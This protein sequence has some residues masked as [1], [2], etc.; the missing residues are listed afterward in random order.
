MPPKVVTV[1]KATEHP[2]FKYERLTTKI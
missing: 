1:V 2:F